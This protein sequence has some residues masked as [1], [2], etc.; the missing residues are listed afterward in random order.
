MEGGN[1][2]NFVFNSF[3]SDFSVKYHPEIQHVYFFQQ[4]GLKTKNVQINSPC[5]AGLIPLPLSV[6]LRMETNQ[7]ESPLAHSRHQGCTF[8][9]AFLAF[10]KAAEK[11]SRRDHSMRDVVRGKEEPDCGGISVL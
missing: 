1:V 6:V 2:P 7:S 5:F 8:N 10:H 9:P 4:S 11:D 3:T